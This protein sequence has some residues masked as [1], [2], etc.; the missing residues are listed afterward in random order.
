[1]QLIYDLAR[2]WPPREIWEI[3]TLLCCGILP[4][5]FTYIDM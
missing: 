1:M 4:E 3:G 2:E 5:T